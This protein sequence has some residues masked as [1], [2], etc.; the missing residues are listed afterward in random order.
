MY[1]LLW[2]KRKKANA[3]LKSS[4][5]I[6]LPGKI[7]QR[8]ILFLQ[9]IQAGAYHNLTWLFLREKWCNTGALMRFAFVYDHSIHSWSYHWKHNGIILVTPDSFVIL[10]YFELVHTQIFYRIHFHLE[11]HSDVDFAKGC[12]WKGEENNVLLHQYLMMQNA[13]GQ[14]IFIVLLWK[15]VENMF[16]WIAHS[17]GFYTSLNFWIS[18]HGKSLIIFRITYNLYHGSKMER[19]FI[20]D[21]S[22]ASIR[23]QLC[24]LNK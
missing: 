21:C 13:K 10:Q 15:W 7:H 24:S 23:I 12:E 3:S 20:A 11:V 18:P 1:S 19:K 14:Y 17:T 5:K 4:V 2:Q 6:Y 8:R 22:P 16:F 9:F